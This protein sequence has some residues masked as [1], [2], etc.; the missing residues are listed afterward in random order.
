MDSPRDPLDA[1]VDFWR[2]D[3]NNLRHDDSVVALMPCRALQAVRISAVIAGYRP[4][5][6]FGAAFRRAR[7]PC[8]IAAVSTRAAFSTRSPHS[9]RAPTAALDTFIPVAINS[10]GLVVGDMPASTEP[11]TPAL[12]DHAPR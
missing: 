11:R 12:L 1:L 3:S 8:T 6:V 5:R 7:C 4:P 9:K 10:A 2:L